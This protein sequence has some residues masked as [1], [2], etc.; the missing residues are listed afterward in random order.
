MRNR[1]CAVNLCGTT[2]KD[3]IAMFKFQKD[4]AIVEEH[5]LV[6]C[7]HWFPIEQSEIC[8]ILMGSEGIGVNYTHLVTKKSAPHS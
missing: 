4:H 8:K 1:K 2:Q 3:H 6:V 7:C 5:T